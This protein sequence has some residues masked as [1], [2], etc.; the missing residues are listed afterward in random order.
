MPEL[1]FR[2]YLL[3]LPNP[4]SQDWGDRYTPTEA[5][6]PLKVQTVV[7]RQDDPTPRQRE[8]PK[9]YEVLAGLRAYAAQ[10]VLLVGK[11]GSGKS[12]A[13]QRLRWEEAQTALSAIEDGQ[14]NFTIPVLIE[15][16]DRR[17]GN[18]INWIQKALRKVRPNETE[19]EDLLLDGRFLLLFDGL[20]EIPL[21]EMW[22][23]LDEFQRDRDFAGNPCIFTTR[24]LGAGSDLGIEKKLEMLPLTELQM[25]EF[26][27]LRLPG[28]AENLLRQLKDRL[29]ELA[30]T[31]L[32]LK[33]LCDVVKESPDGQLPQNRGE[34]FR[35]EFIRRY[36][37][38]KP[39]LT[40]P[41]SGD[42]RRFTSE[43]LQHLAFAMTQG[44]PHTDPCKPTPSWLSISKS[45]AEKILEDYLTG[46]V[47]APA[48]SAKEWLEDLLKFKL[49]V[50]KDQEHIEFIHQLFQEYYAAEKLLGMIDRLSN[51]EL[52][53]D[54]LNY[55]KWT[56]AIALM[57]GLLN[58]KAQA[59]QVV[60]S[61]LEVDLMLG[62]RLA[63]TAQ[64]TIQMQVMELINAQNVPA[65]LKCGLFARTHSEY[66]ISH[67]IYAF[68]DTD[69]FV[70]RN[71]V[72]A[73]GKIG[74]EKAAF[75]LL[76]GLE[77]KEPDVIYETA[78]WLRKIASK[79]LVPDLI[80]AMDK[81]DNYARDKARSIVGNLLDKT[82]VL[83]QLKLLAESDKVIKDYIEIYQKSK[84]LFDSL[85]TSKVI[86]QEEVN[87]SN[88]TFETGSELSV[89]E[90][91]ALV[92]L[93]NYPDF[94]ELLL[95]NPDP[96]VRDRSLE[97]L[98]YQVFGRL[99]ASINSSN[100]EVR[101][102]SFRLGESAVHL[103]SKST[104]DPDWRVRQ[105]AVLLAEVVMTSIYNSQSNL[106]LS[107]GVKEILEE[108]A[109]SLLPLS[110]DP[111]E[112]VRAAVIHSLGSIGAQSAVTT[113][114]E[115]LQDSD[116]AVRV[117]AAYAL[118]EIGD[119]QSIQPLLELMS[120]EKQYAKEVIAYALEEINQKTALLVEYLPFLVNLTTQDSEKIVQELVSS[121][122]KDCGFYN[123]EIAQAVGENVESRVQKADS[124]IDKLN[125]IHKEVKA[126]SEIPRNDFSGSTFNAPINFASNYG[127]Q[128]TTNINTQNNY[129]SSPELEEALRELKSCL[130]ELQT[131]H[132]T[133]TTETQAYEIIE[134]EVI[135][136]TTPNT[137]KLD[138]LRKQLLNPER[139]LKASKAT[140]VEVAK[141]FMEQNIFAKA[142]FTYI[143]KMSEDP[144]K[145]D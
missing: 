107:E 70:R 86:I 114:R 48:Q 25:R 23:A 78:T 17:E 139:H 133:V 102:Y 57:L 31:P 71:V 29:R 21:P 96:Y 131:Q 36:E 134:A 66:A 38:F 141:H 8:T 9:R 115:A 52:K 76:K 109:S 20:N 37:D 43:L 136:P 26:I 24:E 89:E 140:L 63:G 58:N 121:I 30:E 118:G 81:L 77:D 117:A 61:A 87:Q 6:L 95:Q 80:K 62:A 122:Q 91:S 19:V 119:A 59:S 47:D 92:D 111:N 55:L 85:K 142:F 105:Q 40:L 138:T 34:L 53:Q 143:D 124:V 137:R 125:A 132:P 88:N 108:A 2:D 113:F 90:I 10:H 32:I 82:D 104:K 145:G 4:N 54:Y 11:P 46:R 7:P 65:W 144:G 68:S 106:E 14:T 22:S 18:V 3:T 60:S 27:E 75:A 49:L 135:Q 50:V 112:D 56:E 33:M 73:L 5:E 83:E 127:D 100:P 13:L 79:A 123:Y 51:D 72:E 69:W 129:A 103:I 99:K 128:S 101:K 94:Q 74:T 84:S 41:I 28:R 44:D 97:D 120:Y 110:K 39:S 130:A 126:V 1:D 42:S 16:R 15:L 64:S 12:T 116:V 67:L 35:L 45:L 93:I 98:N